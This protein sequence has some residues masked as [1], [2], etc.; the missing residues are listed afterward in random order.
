MAGIFFLYEKRRLLKIIGVAASAII[1]NAHVQSPIAAY[2]G[3][4]NS[5][6]N[7][8]GSIMI[9]TV[10]R[11]WIILIPVCVNICQKNIDAADN[12]PTLDAR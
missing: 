6:P 8:A 5:S 3:Y 1:I 10:S 11:V 7:V 2:T 9:P 12:I 4:W